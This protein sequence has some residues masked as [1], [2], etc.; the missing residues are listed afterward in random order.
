MTEAE[1]AHLLSRVIFVKRVHS[2]IFFRAAH[3]LQVC[4]ISNSLHVN[5]STGYP[6]L[7]LE[8]SAANQ[9]IDVLMMAERF[10][11]AIE[12]SVAASLNRDLS[13]VLPIESH[14]F[15]LAAISPLYS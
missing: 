3:C 13:S 7:N 11:D 1:S 5:G 9:Q 15:N 14:T 12:L 8:I 10:I 6:R 4:F 2:T